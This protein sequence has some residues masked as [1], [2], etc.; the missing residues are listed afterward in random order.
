MASGSLREDFNSLADPGDI[1]FM[2]VNR[3]SNPIEEGNR[4]LAAEMLAKF[5]QA[6][7]EGINGIEIWWGNWQSKSLKCCEDLFA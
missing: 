7:Q 2:D 3:F 6:F 5:F 4:E 1:H